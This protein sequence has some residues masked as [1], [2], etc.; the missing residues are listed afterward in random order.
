MIMKNI[1][2]IIV[3]LMVY[4]L[5]LILFY[6][7]LSK[8]I[9]DLNLVDYEKIY[10]FITNGEVDKISGAIV[11]GF[12]NNPAKFQIFLF[13]ATFLYAILSDIIVLIFYRKIL[14]KSIND[15]ISL[16]VMNNLLIKYFVFYLS[17]VF[18]QFTSIF[19]ILLFL[20]NQFYTFY[21]ICEIANNPE[22]N[23]IDAYKNSRVLAM[24]NRLKVIGC[25]Y[26]TLIFQIL[27]IFINIIRIN[28]YSKTKE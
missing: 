22:I 24:N 16:R 20:I 19:G 14:N 23:F 18:I 12:I 8:F 15:L 5:F 28:I 10:N 27:I 9:L 21:I 1:K 3:Y 7:S 2:K 17:L 25:I 13:I 6:F 4:S 26:L 11:E